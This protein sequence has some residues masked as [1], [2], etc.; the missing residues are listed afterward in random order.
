MRRMLLALLSALSIVSVTGCSVGLVNTTDPAKELKYARRLDSNEMPVEIIESKEDPKKVAVRYGECELNLPKPCRVKYQKFYFDFLD[1]IV[2]D[3]LLPNGKKYSVWLDTGLPGY[4][5]TNGLTIIEND[6]AVYPLGKHSWTSSNSGI[7]YLP[8][9]QIG[10]AIIKNPPCEYLQQH[11]EVKLLWLPVW[12][13]KGVIVGLGLLQHFGY[14][15]FDNVEEE[16][17]LSSEGSFEPN[18]PVRWDSY[19]IEIKTGQLFVNMPVA[20]YNLDLMFDTC[21]RYGMV[22][23]PEVWEKLPTKA[24]AAKIKKSKFISGFLGQLPCRR[25][26]LKK[27]KVGNLIVKN[28][29]VLILPADSPY[30]SAIDSI[31]MKFFKNTAVVLDFKS[32]LMWIKNPQNDG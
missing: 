27:L 17:I 3:G 14:I 12:K 1:L 29:E 2:V 10:Q 25:A 9:L 16:V 21:G 15:V 19:P 22:F 20:G 4:A 31:S 28:A 13:Q 6:L 7:C 32:N 24:K 11:W 5:L 30:S 18:E 23:G 8:S 26:R